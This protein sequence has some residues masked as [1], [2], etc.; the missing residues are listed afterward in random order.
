[1]EDSALL[2]AAKKLQLAREEFVR[3]KS[4][5]VIAHLRA[6]DL[7]RAVDRARADMFSAEKELLGVIYDASEKA[8]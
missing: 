7:E 6:C 5:A 4:D 8:Q 2:K 3:L 1:M